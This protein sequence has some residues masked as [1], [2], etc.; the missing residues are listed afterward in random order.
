MI[1]EDAGSGYANIEKLNSKRLSYV[2]VN[3]LEFNYYKNKYPNLQKAYFDFDRVDAKC[4]VS[5]RSDI[6][7]EKLN[8]AILDMKRQGRLQKI[9]FPRTNTY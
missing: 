5:K 4:A 1:R 9:F 3:N 2:I 8:A 7:I 6:K